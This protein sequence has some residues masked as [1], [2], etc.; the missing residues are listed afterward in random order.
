MAGE[1]SKT[2]FP[3]KASVRC[4]HLRNTAIVKSDTRIA[5]YQI[6]RRRSPTL[7]ALIGDI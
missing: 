1:A 4:G 2:E 6:L 3:S 5:I 7:R